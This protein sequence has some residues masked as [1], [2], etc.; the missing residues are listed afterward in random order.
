MQMSNSKDEIERRFLLSRMPRMPD[1]VT[2]TEIEQGYYF[3]DAQGQYRRVRREIGP[4]GSVHLTSTIKRGTGLIRQE[5]EVRITVA[6]F[7]ALWQKTFGHRICKRRY[8]VPIGA[9]AWEI[10]EFLDRDL[11]LAEIELARPDQRPEVPYWLQTVL[12]REVTGEPGY[13]N[14]ALAGCDL[15]VE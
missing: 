14:I 9:S 3:D 10:D 15:H 6:E 13:L 5:S 4:S 12:V 11:L 7:E 8:C 1:D 2:V